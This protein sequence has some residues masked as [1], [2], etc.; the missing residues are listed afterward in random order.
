MREA[1][2][3]AVGEAVEEWGEAVGEGQSGKAVGPTDLLFP[4]PSSPS[5]QLQCF[6]HHV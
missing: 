2:E 5:F 3:E 1:V 6:C 4:Q